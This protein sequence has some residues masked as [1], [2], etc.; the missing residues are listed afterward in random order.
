MKYPNISKATFVSRPNRFV[1]NVILDNQMQTVH[2]KNTGRCRELLKHGATVYL[3][4]SCNPLRKTKFDLIA[5]EKEREGNSPLLINIDSMAPNDV[6]EEWLPH[7]GLFSS[8]AKIKREYTLGSSRFDF[9]IEDGQRRC[10]IEVKGVTLEN[11]GSVM[12]PDAPTERGVKHLMELSRF[13]EEGY[14]TYILF[15][16][17]L[18]GARFFAPNDLTH[19]AFGDALRFAV[20]HGVH[21]LAYDCFVEPSLIKI[22]SPVEI[23]LG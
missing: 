5:V 10:I 16:I 9:Y 11:N 17:A 19:K 15:I 23:R 21:A 13:G 7:S 12:F 1:A 22:N 14:E 3:T 6:V 20:S 2:V 18:E 8:D 4:N